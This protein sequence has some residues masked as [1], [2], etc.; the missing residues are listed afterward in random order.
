MSG[1]FLEFLTRRQC[2]L[3][4]DAEPT[5]RRVARLVGARL[6]AVDVDQDPD[7]AVDFGLRIPVVRDPAGRVLGEGRLEPGR[8][9]L[10]AARA[11]LR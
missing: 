11:R 3:C 7:L 10:A 6:V 2:H 5:V 1:F 8:L 9:L 4:R